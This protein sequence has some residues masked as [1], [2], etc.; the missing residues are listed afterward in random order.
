MDMHHHHVSIYIYSNIMTFFS[1]TN[2]LQIF[3]LSQNC[4]ESFARLME[5]ST[6]GNQYQIKP[7]IYLYMFVMTKQ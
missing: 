2:D 1:K 6:H 4:L 7:F 5:Q 3:Q